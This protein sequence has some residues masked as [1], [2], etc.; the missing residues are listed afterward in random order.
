M[1]S[2]TNMNNQS[3]MSGAVPL[4]LRY[5]LGVQDAIPAERITRRFQAENP[6]TFSPTNNVVRIPVNSENFLDLRNTVLGFNLK[7]STA[8]DTQWLDGGASCIIQR[9]RVL[10]NSGRELERIEQYNLLSCVLDQYAGSK[11]SMVSDDLLKGA[12][13]YLDETPYFAAVSNTGATDGTST[14]T[15]DVYQ[16]GLKAISTNVNAAGNIT[17]SFSLEGQG[18][19][20]YDQKQAC[21]LATGITRHFEFPLRASGWFNS[22]TGKLLP[23]RSGFVLELTLCPASQAFCRVDST[24][25]ATQDYEATNFILSIPAVMVK[26]PQFNMAMEARMAQG[27]SWS[28]TSYQHHINTTAN[29]YGKDVVQI[30]ARCKELKGLMTI[31]RFQANIGSA[32]EFQNSRRSIQPISQYQ[33]QVGSQNYPPNQITLS[34]DT[35]AGGRTAGS[36]ISVPATADLNISEAYSE[37]QRLFGNLGVQSGAS[38][39]IGAEPFA[40]SENNNGAGLI[41]V[42]LSAFSDGSVMSGIDTQTNALPVSLEIFKT[43][44]VN[45]VVQLD[46]YAVHSVRYIRDPSGELMV[47]F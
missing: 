47:D 2:S 39:V 11:T 16:T 42:D 5:N 6:S 21:Q 7:N 31:M 38:C 9:L 4:G 30:A 33:Y 34:T 3:Q 22:A 23:G 19:I 32:G 35:T 25:S 18:G 17:T 45:A 20:G 27:L 13:R 10:S 26:D 44:V 8:T 46:T 29:N 40:Q 28:S 37:V 1:E 41:A 12:S 15:V 36:R 43:A 14:A 24:G